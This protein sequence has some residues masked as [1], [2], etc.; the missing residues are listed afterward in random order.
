MFLFVF[1][2]VIEQPAPQLPVRNPSPSTVDDVITNLDPIASTKQPLMLTPPAAAGENDNINERRRKLSDTSGPN[3]LLQA[4]MLSEQQAELMEMQ[5]QEENPSTLEAAAASSSTDEALPLTS[6]PSTST[7]AAAAEVQ[8]NSYSTNPVLSENIYSSSIMER[9]SSST[10]GSSCHKGAH[11]A[12]WSD[13]LDIDA[14]VVHQAASSYHDN[15]NIYD[16]ID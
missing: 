6:K 11:V 13:S 15:F 16:T 10:S 2:L 8:L 3:W 9:S 4:K 12:P 7:A 5:I 1:H 14:V